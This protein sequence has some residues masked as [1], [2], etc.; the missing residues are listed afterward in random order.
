MT[1][2]YRC[3]ICGRKEGTIKMDLTFILCPGHLEKVMKKTL[4][5][6]LHPK[7]REAEKDE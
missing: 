1:R 5:E 3:K 6:I 2:A 7:A 4:E